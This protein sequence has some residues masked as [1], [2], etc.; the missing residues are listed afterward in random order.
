MREWFLLAGVV[1]SGFGLGC[2]WD[3]DTVA[4][5]LKGMPE[6]QN[7]IAGRFERNPDLFYEMRIERITQAGSAM[8]F[9]YY[10][11][12]FRNRTSMFKSQ[13]HTHTH[14]FCIDK[15]YFRQS[16][17]T[18]NSEHVKELK[19]KFEYTKKDNHAHTHTLT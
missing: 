13:T 10:F 9:E 8:K 3:R 19:G 7:V 14:I 2:L 1:I 15:S 4:M 6:I 11:T 12:Y 18:I 16:L 17:N 5:E